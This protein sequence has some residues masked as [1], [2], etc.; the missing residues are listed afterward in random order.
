[1]QNLADSNPQVEEINAVVDEL[2]RLRREIGEAPPW[3]AP[4]SCRCSRALFVV[5]PG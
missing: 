2:D 1:L 4:S 5:S 3:D